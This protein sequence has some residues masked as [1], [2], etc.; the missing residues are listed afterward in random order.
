MKAVI[1]DYNWIENEIKESWV[2]HHFSSYQIFDK[3]HR[4]VWINNPDVIH[5]KNSGQNIYDLLDYIINNYETLEDKLFFS[6]GCLLFPKLQKKPLSSGNC[7]KERFLTKLKSKEPLVEV[8]DYGENDVDGIF[9]KI[10]NDGYFEKVTSWWF[11]FHQGKYYFSFKIFLKDLFGEKYK[12]KYIRYSPGAAYIINKELI[13]QY[14]KNL[15]INLRFLVSWECI[16]GEAHMLER[17]FYE[18]FVNKKSISNFYLMNTNDFQKKIKFRQFQTILWNNIM[19]PLLRL[20][21]K[22]FSG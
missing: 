4:E 5:Q 20:K 6:R 18:L 22:V 8:N 3:F 16:V 19:H 15:Y 21:T 9:N 17:T 13:Q 11:R 1:S 7:S 12:K 14:P 10:E 2:G